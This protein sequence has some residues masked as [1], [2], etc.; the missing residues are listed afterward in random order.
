MLVLGTPGDMPGHISIEFAGEG[1]LLVRGDAC[2][3]DVIFFEHPS[4]HFDFDTD[5]ETALKSRQVSWIGLRPRN[6][7]CS[8]TGRIQA[9]GMRRAAGA[10]C[11]HE[12]IGTLNVSDANGLKGTAWQSA[13]GSWPTS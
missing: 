11:V 4:W 10:I 12:G 13:R 2:T 1:N 7:E 6:C 3:S 5:A 9:S 8:A